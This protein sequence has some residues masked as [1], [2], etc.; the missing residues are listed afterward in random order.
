[1]EKKVSL[2]ISFGQLKREVETEQTRMQKKLE[3]RQQIEEQAARKR[4][5][6]QND[7]ELELKLMQQTDETLKKIEEEN[8]KA[9]EREIQSQKEFLKVSTFQ[10]CYSIKKT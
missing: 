7:Q 5:S 6:K 9:K 3:M 4:Q 8:K 2:F 1:M 10:K